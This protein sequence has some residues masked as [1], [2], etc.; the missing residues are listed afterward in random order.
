MS[1][2]QSEA[3]QNRR[4]RERAESNAAT[5]AAKAADAAASRVTEAPSEFQPD[6]NATT[7]AFSRNK[8][9]EPAREFKR[10]NPNR[11]A[12][13][14]QMMADRESRSTEHVHEEPRPEP[15]AKEEPRPDPTPTATAVEPA[16]TA[17]EAPPA[18]APEFVEVKIDGEVRSVAKDEVEEYGGV[19]P[20]QIAKAQEKRLAEANRYAQEMGNMF[21]Q[22][23]AQVQKP[24][25]PQQKPEEKLGEIATKLQLG[26]P[27]EAR[28]ALT[29][30]KELVAPKAIDPQAIAMQ[31]YMLNRVTEA[32]NRFV[33]D[34]KDLIDNP[35]IKQMIIVEKD[36]RLNQFRQ[37]N[38]L[39][40]D[41]NAFYTSLATD[42][43]AALG[44]PPIATTASQQPAVQ[45]TSG[46]A[47]KS[48]RKA[49]IV[50]LPTAASRAA[51]PEAEKPLTRDELL[52]RARKA[53]GQPV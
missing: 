13:Y 52:A 21:R 43:R 23:Q 39:P 3:Q 9:D 51:A 14:E 38:Q 8:S 22:F 27:D 10:G 4:I 50:A 32:E 35:M 7:D 53:R 6:P 24:A 40:N 12:A 26:T 25:E 46:L 16:A 42:V 19:R 18:P 34:N 20:Y 33:A 17:V 44:R 29:E 49:D 37:Q 45:P 5:Q 41:W 1:S 15:T 30:L 28:Q 31:A 48:A 47:E 2:K 36:R 11:T